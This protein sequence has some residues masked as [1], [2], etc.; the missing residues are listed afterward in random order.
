MS[1]ADVFMFVRLIY[2]YVLILYDNYYHIV[3]GNSVLFIL[4]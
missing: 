1:D 4:F 3:L 2:L